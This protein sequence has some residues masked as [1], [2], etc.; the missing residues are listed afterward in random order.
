ML[1]ILLPLVKGRLQGAECSER[2]L[3]ELS[4]RE[5]RHQ[6]IVVKYCEY[7][8]TYKLWLLNCLQT[9]QVLFCDFNCSVTDQYIHSSQHKDN[10]R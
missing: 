6:K 9:L 5:R 1:F 2:T 10:Y 4:M 7:T 8:K 3:K